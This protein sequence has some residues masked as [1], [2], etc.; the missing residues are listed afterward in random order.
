MNRLKARLLACVLPAACVSPALAHAQAAAAAGAPATPGASPAVSEVIVT[1]RRR[2]ENLAR[3]P[4]AVTAFSGQQ[5]VEKQ[6]RSDTDL[7]LATP[8]LTVRQTQ[9]PN[10]LTFSIRGQTA[11]TFSG[12]P[13]AVVAYLNEVQLT[14]SA[15]SSFYDMDSV[16]VLKG[17]QGTLFGR[18]ATG[19]AVLY[20]TAKPTNDFSG[21]VRGRAGNLSLGEAEGALNLPLVQDKVLLRAAFDVI[22][23]DGFIH[24]DFT[25]Q[26]LGQ[27][28]RQSGRVT[29]TLKPVETVSNT[30]MFQYTH[31]GGTNTGASYLY[32]A[33]APGQTN[34]GFPLF[35]TTGFLYGPTLDAAFGPGAWNTYLAQHPKAFAPGLL[36][37][38]D[39][40]RRLGPR[41]SN[42][43]GDETHRENDWFIS[44][45]T[46]VDLSDNLLLRNILGF[47]RSWT[48]SEASS[49]AAP[50]NI[51]LSENFA[52]GFKGNR[53][54]ADSISEEL[55]LQGKAFD[56][57]L[58][59]V[60][61][62][63]FQRLN[64]DTVWPQV[65]FELLPF[66]P[67]ANVTSAFRTRNRTEAVYA[68]GTYDLASLTGVDG[69]RVT[70]GVRYTWENVFFEH[71][72]ESSQF[73][74]LP[75]SRDFG[76][77]SWEIGLEYQAT[78]SLFTYVKTRG[79]FRSGGF[80]GAA[81][82]LPTDATG[83]GNMFNAEHTHD[84]ELGAKWR[85]DLLGR[86]A[87][88]NVA[89]FNQWIYDVQHVEFPSVPSGSIAVTVNVPAA[90]IRGIEADAAFQ[91]TTWLELGAS[92]SLTDGKYTQP[93]VVLFG[94][95]FVYGPFA[96]TPKASGVV[97]GQAT[98][99]DDPAV[100]RF[101]LRGEV[102]AQ[103]YQYFSSS[104]DSITPGTKLPGYALLN[105]RLAWDDIQGGPISAA[106]FGRN[107]TDKTYFTGGI[108]LGASLG[109]NSAT[110]GE[111]RTV[112]LEVTAKF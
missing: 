88:L 56:S 46:N 63:Y 102:Y 29:L 21:Y 107:L 15:A 98:L 61:G 103:T 84:V 23:R 26:E 106:I 79:S 76:D 109:V 50:Y 82:A 28:R 11:D 83:G 25:G 92:T 68:Q 42:Y 38:V 74:A 3:V 27:I 19:G 32:S 6:I 111:P 77:P 35:G 73:G 20:S 94:T 95:N 33:Y 58:T 101:T 12:T 18:N 64:V 31:A 8:G 4:V 110:V 80:N 60:V 72:R 1:A 48:H 52:T 44:N 45:V 104:F 37:Y 5:L 105:A 13:S 86:P 108:P 97:Y 43:P 10:T 40:Q 91:P 81:P 87:S 75:Q 36:A 78:P 53:V 2:A 17:P 70:A 54:L 7:Q 89:L 49:L 30:T 39:E 55:Q 100:G 34:N 41:V 14:T 69:L 57:K 66:I 59:Y 24:N 90:V 62:A 16:Q 51:F 65:Y 71:M 67:P 22:N 9:G 85:G 99:Y 112:G 96:D 93:N 47:S